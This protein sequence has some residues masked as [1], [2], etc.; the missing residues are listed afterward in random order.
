MAEANNAPTASTR[1]QD[2]D[3]DHGA[4]SGVSTPLPGISTPNPD[5]TDKRFPGIHNSTYFAQVCDT[6]CAVL[7]VSE[8]STNS[9]RTLSTI[10]TKEEDT[11]HSLH[12]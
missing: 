12:I 4:G 6:F 7:S 2:E 1:P 11:L 8:I 10:H 3:S 9:P 5:F